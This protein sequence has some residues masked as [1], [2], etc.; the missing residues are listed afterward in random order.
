MY[1]RKGIKIKKRNRKWKRKRWVR[2]KENRD[3]YWEKIKDYVKK[4][5]E[6]WEMTIGNFSAKYFG[7]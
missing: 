4:R 2:K 5:K 6:K 1:S 3:E 7:Y